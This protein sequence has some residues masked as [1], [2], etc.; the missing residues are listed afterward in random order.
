VSAAICQLSEEN[1]ISK[2]A[3][4]KPRSKPPHP[5]N[6]LTTLGFNFYSLKK[7]FY[8]AIKYKIKKFLNNGLVSSLRAMKA[9]KISFCYSL[10]QGKSHV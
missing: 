3:L 10:V 1:T 9:K 7:I 4:E 8:Y 5:E 2:P 6:K